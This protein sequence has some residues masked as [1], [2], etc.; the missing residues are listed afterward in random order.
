MNLFWIICEELQKRI[1]KQIPFS[2]I[3]IDQSANNCL[4]Y[5][6]NLYITIHEEGGEIFVSNGQYE[7][8]KM[9]IRENT[10]NT[11]FDP[12]HPDFF[13]LIIEHVIDNIA[14]ANVDKNPPTN[15]YTPTS[16]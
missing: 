12:S 1:N 5:A 11:K 10:L 14:Y 4:V 8:G 15:F 16:G 13:D 3:K 6:G 2:K 7:S 9:I